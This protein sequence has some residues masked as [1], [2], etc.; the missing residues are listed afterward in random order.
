LFRWITEKRERCGDRLRYRTCVPDGE[1][2]LLAGNVHHL[3]LEVDAWKKDRLRDLRGGEGEREGGCGERNKEATDGW[4]EVL[5]GVG[6]E[7][8]EEAAL[9]D[10][11]V[12]DEEELEEVVE[13]GLRRGRRG[14]GRRGV[15]GGVITPTDGA[16]RSGDRRIGSLIYR[17]DRRGEGFALGW[18]MEGEKRARE[19]RAVG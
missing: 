12:A 5:E 11:G 17:W 9:A 4:G 2:E 15:H 18:G 1:L 7:S 3:D 19:K 13:V 16:A 8:E 14:H 6:G 10:A